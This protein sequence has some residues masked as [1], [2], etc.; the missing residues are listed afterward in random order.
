MQTENDTSK[1]EDSPQQEAGEGCSGATC[2]PCSCRK[3]YDADWIPAEFAP[4]DHK[5]MGFFEDIGWYP[6]CWSAEKEMWKISYCAGAP[7]T[8]PEEPRWIERMVY[9]AD[10][11]WW[12][13]WPNQT[14]PGHSQKNASVELP[15]NGGSPCSLSF[16]PPDNHETH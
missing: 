2:S 9:E 12:R 8:N 11:C 3:T 16:E 1:P 14:W 7:D 5:I 15:P 4:K 6:A 10:L 13:K